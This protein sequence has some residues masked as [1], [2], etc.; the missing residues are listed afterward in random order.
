VPRL[1]WRP[2]VARAAEIVTEYDTAVT[3]RQVF[4]RLVAEQ[5]IP[6]TESAYKRLSRLTADLRREG[7]F[8]P[9]L[10]RT[11]TIERVQTYASPAEALEAIAHWYRRDL[12]EGQTTLPMIVVEKATLVAQVGDWFGALTLPIAALRGYASE[13]YERDILNLV[14]E[15]M[16]TSSR[17][18]EILY[19]G[20]FDPS[21]EDIPRSFAEHMGMPIKRVALTPEQVE[22]YELP[23][24]M[25]KATDSRAASFYA[26]HGRLVQVELEALPP[27]VLRDLLAVELDALVDVS[28][29]EGVRE[30]EANER[31]WLDGLTETWQ[32]GSG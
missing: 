18:V 32:G 19:C 15:E 13:S 23:E 4:Y 31:R 27:E 21:G 8:P 28:L 7:E 16:D 26:R 29:T 11:R 22:Q 10:D 14:D 30:R 6:N 5:R 3:L 17:E 2:I 20:D 9:L 1:D 24:A 12:L 25:G